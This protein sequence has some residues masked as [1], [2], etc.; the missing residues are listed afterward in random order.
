[1]ERGTGW[2]REGGRRPENAA[3]ELYNILVDFGRHH[4]HT[5]SFGISLFLGLGTDWTAANSVEDFGPD[6]ETNTKWRK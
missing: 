2:K 4:Q 6:G 1:M 3:H 5:L